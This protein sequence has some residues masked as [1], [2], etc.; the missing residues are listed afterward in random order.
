MRFRFSRSSGPGGQNVNKVNTKATLHVD[1]D[2][3]AEA[4]GPTALARLLKIAGRQWC[5]EGLVITSDEHR[6][7]LANRRAC[8]AKLRNLIVRARHRPRPRKRTRPS[9][10]SV[11]RRLKAKEHRSQIKA[12]RGRS[13][14]DDA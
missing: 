5:E 8:T 7:Q 9:A 2:A 11:E 4:I 1:P 6:S 14:L 13:G 12:L 10:G 3:L